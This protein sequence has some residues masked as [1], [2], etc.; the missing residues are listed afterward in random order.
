MY[1]TACGIWAG[2][3]RLLYPRTLLILG[4]TTCLGIAGLFGA[5]HHLQATL[6]QASA[7]ESVSH[8]SQ[9]L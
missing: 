7:L 9:A 6:L 2:A 8:Y 4:I 1:Q 5:F 3:V